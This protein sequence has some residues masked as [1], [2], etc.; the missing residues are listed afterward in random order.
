MTDIGVLHI[1]I[2]IGGSDNIAQHVHVHA[3]YVVYTC[4]TS[5]I[6]RMITSES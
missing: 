1:A 4:G 3:V 6:F 5:T 2:S